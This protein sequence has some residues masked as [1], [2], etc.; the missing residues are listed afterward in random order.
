MDEKRFKELV[1]KAANAYEIDLLCL[2][3]LQAAA[4]GEAPKVREM[5]LSGIEVIRKGLE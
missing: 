1:A 5:M 2:E 4:N 3:W